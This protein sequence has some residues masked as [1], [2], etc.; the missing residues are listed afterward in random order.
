MKNKQAVTVLLLFILIGCVRSSRDEAVLA[1]L[2]SL[3]DG[4]FADEGNQP[5][6]VVFADPLTAGVFKNLGRVGGGYHVAP[7]EARLVWPSVNDR[8]MPGN[9]LRVYF[10]RIQGDR[11]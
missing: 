11:A 7:K 10:D 4:G 9:Q 3:L 5:V 2:G 6:Y 1:P 8:G